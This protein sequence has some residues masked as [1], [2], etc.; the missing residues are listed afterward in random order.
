MISGYVTAS[1][2]GEGLDAVVS[3][4]VRGP[5]GLETDVEMVVDTGYHGHIGLPVG[6]VD[7]LEMP[8][9][10]SFDALLANGQRAR[11]DLYTG[12]IVWH[13]ERRRVAVTATEGGAI[14]GMS[15]LEGNALTVDVVEGGSITIE[16][17]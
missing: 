12:F 1:D 2:A 13:G 9:H 4:R 17:R 5:G 7:E 15:L 3:L 11:M 14:L 8:Y 6:L 10:S 16:E